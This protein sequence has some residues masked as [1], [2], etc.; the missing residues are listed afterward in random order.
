[1]S[2]VASLGLAYLE[3]KHKLSWSPVSLPSARSLCPEAAFSPL[4]PSKPV[5]FFS[6]N[7]KHFPSS[8]QKKKKRTEPVLKPFLLQT[9]FLVFRGVKKIGGIIEDQV[10]GPSI[11]KLIKAFMD[12]W[13]INSLSVCGLMSSLLSTALCFSKGFLLEYSCLMIFYSQVIQLS[14]Y[15]HLLFHIVFPFRLL[16]S[17]EQGSL[18]YTVG[19]CWSCILNIAVCTLSVRFNEHNEVFS[20]LGMRKP[21]LG[22]IK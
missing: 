1:M 21:R 2:V 7:S 11:S 3:K 13:H 10:H 16:Q 17:T 22:E 12:S 4:Y 5:S 20:C 15:M 6:R 18:W 8:E 19:P 9:F 14:I